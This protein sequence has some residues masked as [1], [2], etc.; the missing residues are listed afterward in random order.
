MRRPS[1]AAVLVGL[2][3]AVSTLLRFWGGSNVPIPW[4]NPDEI[5]YGELGRSLWSSGRFTILGRP[6]EFISLVYPALAG[7]PLSLGNAERGYHLLKL[8]QALVMSLTAVPVYLWARSLGTRAYAFL[9]A[10]LTLAIPGLAYSGLIM[11]EVAFYPIVVLAAY[12]LAAA[13]ECPTLGRQGLVV[14]TFAAAALTRLQ[15]FVLLPVLVTAVGIDVAFTRRPRRLLRFVPSAGGLV[16]LALV[17]A[18]WRLRNGG[19]LSRVFGAYE[20]AG[21]VHYGLGRAARYVL[22]HYADLALF[23]GL[24]PLVAVVALFVA[25]DRRDDRLRAYLAT[26][27]ALCLWFP[28]EVGVFASQHVG[29]LAE[30]NMLPLAPVLFVGF[31]VWLARGAPRPRLATAAAIAG[32]LALLVALPMQKLVRPEAFPDSFTL[33]PLIRL[34]KR[35]PGT[36]LDLLVP[37][38][39]AG[40][41]LVLALVPRRFLAVLPVAL[42]AVFGAISIET[43]NRIAFESDFLAR[44]STGPFHRWIDERAKGPVAYLYIGEAN[45]P[46]AWENL[47]WNR[48]VKH[49]YDLLTARIPGGLPQDSVGPLEDGRL[50]GIG[51]FPAEGEYAVSQY[52]VEFR[53]RVVATAGEG[54][55][56]WRLDPPF[57]IAVWT[58]RVPGHLRV[59]DYACRP[60]RLRLEVVG[61]SGSPID[62]RRNERPYRRVLVPDG[63]TWSGSIP[64]APPRPV[65]TRLCTFDVFTETSTTVPVARLVRP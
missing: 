24:F 27:V 6:S 4:I 1:R 2:L 15:A 64:A 60:G 56:L 29:Y 28:L 41:L 40:A 16:L 11:T 32:V 37:L 48:R 43:S 30:R 58:Q 20:P 38:V 7:L 51:G 3:V 50:V 55:Q 13:L 18:G 25:A 22:Y 23:T 44:Q 10:A 36:D 42:L 46:G 35:S 54:L 14:V 61:L 9:A 65:G 45:W 62:L 5:I 8:I 19:P 21:Q 12:A 63:G 49:V 39:C 47:F 59:L 34:E 33:L 26:A 17:W 31:A 52:P 57:R 53:G